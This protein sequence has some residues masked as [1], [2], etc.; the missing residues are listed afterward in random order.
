M[1]FVSLIAIVVIITHTT[2]AS[3]AGADGRFYIY[4]V[5]V[6]V[7]GY[8]GSRAVT[9]TTVAQMMRADLNDK[10][11]GIA[12]L[13]RPVWAAIAA[14]MDGLVV[15]G[16]SAFVAAVLAQSSAPLLPADASI[17]FGTLAAGLS[18]PLFR[19]FAHKMATKPVKPKRVLVPAA[20]SFG[21]A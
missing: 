14:C 21:G 16:S 19:D 5:I 15:A 4:T 1:T 3:N 12:V 17:S 18:L 10:A 20:Q 2:T 8:C 7:I 11:H 9:G 13:V 6:G